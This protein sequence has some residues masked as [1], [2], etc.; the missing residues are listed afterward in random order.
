MNINILNPL[1]GRGLDLRLFLVVAIVFHLVTWFLILRHYLLY[2]NQLE[3]IIVCLLVT[4]LFLKSGPMKL[5]MDWLLVIF[6][7]LAFGV[8]STFNSENITMSAI[9]A[10]T[11]FLVFSLSVLLYVNFRREFRNHGRVILLIPVLVFVAFALPTAISDIFMVAEVEKGFWEH[12]ILYSPTGL[13]ENYSHIRHFSYHSFIA[14]SFSYILIRSL[15]EN[16]SFVELSLVYVLFTVCVLA[17]ILAGGRGSILALIS[18]I[19]FNELIRNGFKRGCLAAAIAV[20]VLVLF[21]VTLLVTPLSSVTE[22]IFFRSKIVASELPSA[23]QHISTGRSEVWKQAL[24]LGLESPVIGYGSAS[25]RWLPG[26]WQGDMFH[27]HNIAIQYVLEY[28]YLGGGIILFAIFKFLKQFH[29]FERSDTK[30]NIHK[31]LYAFFLSYL[32]FSMVDGL[33]YHVL[34]MLHLAIALAVYMSFHVRNE[35][36][37]K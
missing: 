29:P 33:F 19:F 31:P 16:P 11:D 13:L 7:V 15:D 27:P 10:T 22:E 37:E 18:L 1:N 34:P 17:M 32:L 14:A 28:G 9:K 2:Q 8:V 21:L 26:P 35:V 36:I 4:A 12:E 24:V 25:F 6:L 20:L 23:I 30:T 3:L 5:S